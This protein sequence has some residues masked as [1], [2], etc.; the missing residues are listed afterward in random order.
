MRHNDLAKYHTSPPTKNQTF[1]KK[2]FFLILL[3]HVFWC[4]VS[5]VFGDDSC[6]ALSI[7]QSIKA[8]TLPSASDNIMM[9]TVC[10]HSVSTA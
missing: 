7:W 4:A 5:V 3:F 9:F 10:V 1:S 6:G 2:F 8:L